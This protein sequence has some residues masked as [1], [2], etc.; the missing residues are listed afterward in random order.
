LEKRRSLSENRRE[1]SASE[2]F[3]SLKELVLKKQVLSFASFGSEIN[4]WR[5]N[6]F[7]AEKKLLL[8]P[9]MNDGNLEVY[10]IVDLEKDL[11]QNPLGVWE[12]NPESCVKWDASLVDIVLVPG[13][14]FD[15][16]NRRIGYGKGYYDRFLQ[17]TAIA[18][19]W[20]IG[21]KEQLADEIPVDPHDQEMDALYLF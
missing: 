21:F 3:H 2:L 16:N 18:L 20:G 9:R 1:Q 12:P 4:S 11:L 19:K 5:L 7:L 14:A 17:K 10:K 13:V 15:L 8:L 6:F